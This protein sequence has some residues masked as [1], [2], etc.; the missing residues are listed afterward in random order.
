MNKVFNRIFFV[1]FV[2]VWLVIGVIN[3][4]TP[5]KEYSENEN[6]YLSKFPKY[7]FEGIVNGKFMPGVENYINEQFILRDNWISIQSVLEYGLGKRESN[8]VYICSN[9]LIGKFGEPNKDFVEGNILGINSF[10]E[11]TGIP[12]KLMIVPGA[13]AIQND[14]LPPYATPYDHMP[15][16]EEIYSK[17]NVGT[18]SVADTL[19]EHK[20]NY[21]YYRTDHHWTTYG[22][23]L[24]YVEYCKSEGIIP[25]EYSA[26][27]VSDSFN[28]TLYSKSGVRFIKSDTIESYNLKFD[29]S[30]EVIVPNSDNIK[31]D[32]IYY[33]ENLIGKD[34]YT[35]FLGDNKAVITAF[36][37]REEKIGKKLLVVKDSY[38][39]CMAPMLLEH[40]DEVTF[41]DVRYVK[42]KLNNY[43]DISQYDSCLFLF[44]AD[45]FMNEDNQNNLSV[46][47]YLVSE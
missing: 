28:G 5:Y 11:T 25:V 26:D 9:A 4:L 41:I 3:V 13:S 47:K 18:V 6:K 42:L 29:T 30:C 31:N 33:E 23:Y 32:S 10:A 1:L 22:A 15:L 14:N 34:Q 24:G 21:I 35:Y 19:T 16:I 8:G 38:A 45:G 36:A 2:V 12:T 27:M 37:Q 43:I 44:S 17:V 20:D 39:H 7:S 40:Y 46:L